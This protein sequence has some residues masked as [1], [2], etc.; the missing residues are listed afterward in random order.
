MEFIELWVFQ[1][2]YRLIFGGLAPSSQISFLRSSLA[3]QSWPETPNGGKSAASVCRQMA[4]WFPDM[5]WNFYLV[6]NRKIAKTSTTS[7]AREMASTQL[8]KSFMTWGHA[9]PDKGPHL[10]RIVKRRVSLWECR[11]RGATTLSITTLSIMTLS[12]KGLFATLSIMSLFVTLSITT[13]PLIM[14]SAA[15]YLVF[16]RMSLCS[17]SLCWESW[18]RTRNFVSSNHFKPSSIDSWPD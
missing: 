11:T 18:T 6:K 8:P 4:A 2:H 9:E 5:F 3:K 13:L 17:V 12:I 1:T 7:K 14:L 16:C 15:F 10:F